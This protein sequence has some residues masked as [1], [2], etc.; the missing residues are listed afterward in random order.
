[1]SESRDLFEKFNKKKAGSVPRDRRILVLGPPRSGKS[2][3]ISRYLGGC[4]GEHIVGLVKTVKAP[5][6]PSKIDVIKNFFKKLEQFFPLLERANHVPINRSTKGLDKL[7]QEDV[8][9]LKKLLGDRAPKYIVEDIASKIEETKSS[10]VIA[11][12]IPWDINGDINEGLLDEEVKKA[13]EIIRSAFEAHGAKVKW[14][15]AEYI[16][17]GFVKEVL[18]LLNRETEEKE[19]ERKVGEM[20]EAYVSI[21]KSLDLLEGVEW[22]SHFVTSARTFTMDLARRSLATIPYIA[23]NILLGALTTAL[24]TLFTNHIIRTPQSGG[25]N[26]IVNLKINLEK[27]K[28]EKPSNEVCGKFSELG[29]IVAYKIATALNLD[30]ED[31]CGALAEIA[32]IEVDKLKEIVEDLSKRITEVEERLKLTRF[33]AVTGIIIFDRSEFIEGSRGEE[34][35]GEGLL[36]PD[37]KVVDGKLSIRV[38]QN[39]YSV[40]EAGAFGTA[41]NNLIDKIKRKRVVVVVGP[42]GIGKSILAASII[43]RLFDNGDIGLVAGVKKLNKDNDSHFIKFIE[44]YL[45]R[46][47][48]VFGELLILY[49]PSTTRVYEKEREGQPIPEDIR[50]SIG[51]LLKIINSYR[52]DLRILIV[53]PEDIYDGLGEDIRN[54]LNQ[55]KLELDLSDAVFLAEV[56]KEYSSKVCRDKLDENKLRDLVNEI[57]R[58]NG[59]H[60]LIARLAGTLLAK[61]FKCNIDDARK[62]VDE[63]KREA[64]AFIAGFINS[65][66]E[67][68]DDEDRARVLAEVFAIRKPF[69]DSVDPGDPILT[70]GIVK[71]IKSV[72]NPGFEM[73]GEKAYWLSIRHND[74][75]EY[76]IENLLSKKDLGE[77]SEVWIRTEIPEITD[78]VEYFINNYGDKF[79]KKIDKSSWKRLALIAGHVLAG[80]II[81]P[82]KEDLSRVLDEYLNKSENLKESLEEAL[83]SGVI[84]YYLIV[85]NEIPIFVYALVLFHLFLEKFNDFWKNFVNREDLIKSIVSDAE[86]LLKVWSGREGVF[87]NLVA[88]Y[89][90]GLAV[91]TS[92]AIELGRGISEEDASTILKAARPGV[93]ISLHPFYVKHILILLMRLGFKAPQHY[94]SLLSI[95]SGRTMLDKN[96]VSFIFDTLKVHSNL[97]YS[98]E[99]KELVSL[100]NIVEVYSN[101]LYKHLEVYLSLLS[102]QS[103]SFDKIEDIARKMCY[104]LNVLRGK[105]PELATIAEA[106]VLIPSLERRDVEG[107][108]KEYCSINDIIAEADVVLNNL[109]GMAGDVSKLVGN[110]TFMEWIKTKTFNLSKEGVRKMISSIE[111]YFTSGLA[112]YKL[113]VDRLDE[114]R[115]LYDKAAGIDKSIGAITNYLVDSSWILRVDVIKA[116]NL[117]DYANVAKDF[118]NLWNEALK[119]LKPSPDYFESRSFHLVNYLVYLASI[120]RH[121]DV[122]GLLNKY[123]YLLN[124]DEEL[125]VL[126]KLMLKILGYTRTEISSREIVDAYS[127]SIYPQFLPALKLALGIEADHD[128]LAV[129]GIEVAIRF[130][131][132][133]RHRQYEVYERVKDLDAKL[134]VQLLAP[135]T[136][137]ARLAFM[138]Y[139]LANGD[140]DLARIHAL[141]GS[142]EAESELLSRLFRE[143]HDSCCDIGDEGF[144]LALLKL[145]YYHI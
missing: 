43:W 102:N 5:G 56:A 79:I 138:L 41:I 51:N 122:E 142:M 74:L 139:S 4:G 132:W 52:E 119:N 7:D 49:D 84:D 110:E 60:A 45:E 65:Y 25:L 61:E 50:E 21:L 124:Y 44:N 10:S 105:S 22:E 137:K 37:I 40:I 144:K 26:E 133:V 104:L 24:I 14:L 6:Q 13:V 91:I 28:A 96:K 31:V 71:V 89:A 141:L 140:T 101:L 11:Y 82:S 81:L 3:F 128:E 116:S 127:V 34:R 77:A 85:N 92:K 145:F 46:S 134:L 106:F 35:G 67:I 42:R 109:E 29:K 98:N 15:N 63:S 8:E 64:T 66:F 54:V 120:G 30:V 94:T 78:P 20:V 9:E 115:K 27:L 48:E 17:P 83:S 39:Y 86:K 72:V 126:T 80:F 136:S 73:P 93:R 99:F 117:N 38:E 100:V 19:V 69:V 47:R 70:P 114:A 121:G 108:V 59:G 68:N 113:T 97:K 32:G 76:T 12:Y 135:K 36:Y 75:I 103:Q 1:M 112:R 90:L 23:G 95:L 123:A 129:K 58:F 125:S 143:A 55:Y 131:D 111:G 18:D 88:L 33:M 16:P 2:T 53:L 130:K 118:E 107:Y 87:Q 62:V 57:A